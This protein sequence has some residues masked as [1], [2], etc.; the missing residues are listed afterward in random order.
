MKMSGRIL[1]NCLCF[2]A[3]SVCLAQEVGVI[4]GV[5]SDPNGKPLSG[6][7]VDARLKGEFSGHRLDRSSKTSFDGKFVID[8][9]SWGT[10]I[11]VAR[12]ED[13]DY[14]DTRLAFYSNLQ[15]PSVT[16]SATDPN[17]DV[18]IRLAPQAGRLDLLVMNART[19]ERLDSAAVTLRRVEN[20]KPFVT[21]STTLKLIA[22]PALTDVQVEITAPGYNPWPNGGSALIINLQSREGKHLEVRL[23]PRS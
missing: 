2:C 21:M 4:Q 6:A 16:I 23:V 11:L 8:H 1:V 13:S 15:A 17:K 20:P 14:P 9:L 10:Y 3:W 22:I 12:K 18:A 5:V 7:K 19:G